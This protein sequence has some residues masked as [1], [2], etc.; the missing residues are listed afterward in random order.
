VPAC[1]LEVSK[2]AEAVVLSNLL[3]RFQSSAA[4]Y[5]IAM[6]T[7]AGND[8]TNLTECRQIRFRSVPRNPT[9]QLIYDTTYN[10]YSNIFDDNISCGPDSYND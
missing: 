5:K 9:S 1:D 8:S 3:L 2:G 6:P 4:T 10:V 7:S